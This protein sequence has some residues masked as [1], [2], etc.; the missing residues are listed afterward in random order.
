[1]PI[2]GIPPCKVKKKLYLLSI[3]TEDLIYGWINIFFGFVRNNG[4]PS[5]G[6]SV[7]RMKSY[8]P[9]RWSPQSTRAYWFDSMPYSYITFI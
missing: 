6:G 2:V 5:S 7:P 8:V 4:K 9:D 3:S 1:M